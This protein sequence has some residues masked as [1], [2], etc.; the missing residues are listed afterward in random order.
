M[1]HACPSTMIGI[2][3]YNNFQSNFMAYLSGSMA[4]Q[5]ISLNYECIDLALV[6]WKEPSGLVLLKH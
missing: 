2:F 5:D 6:D 1:Y 3:S 4:I